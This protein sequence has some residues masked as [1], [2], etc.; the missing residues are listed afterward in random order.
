MSDFTKVQ[1]F[2]PI[3]GEISIEVTKRDEQETPLV[4]S[5]YSVQIRPD[6]LRVIMLP[7][8]PA[9]S[10]TTGAIEYIQGA[11]WSISHNGFILRFSS[12]NLTINGVP[13]FEQPKGDG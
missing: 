9:E 11:G 5:A 2:D 3:T 4:E 12:G 13:V 10:P 8:V 7:Q 1:S 6:Y